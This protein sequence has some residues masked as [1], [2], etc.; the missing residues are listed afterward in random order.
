MELSSSTPEIRDICEKRSKARAKLGD[1]AALELGRI[2][3]DIEAFDSFPA[4][5]SMFGDRITDRGEAEKSFQME[6]G[7]LI[8]FRAGHPRN[9]GAGAIPTDWANTTRLLI[10]A[11]ETPDA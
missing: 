5:A 11:I 1:D 7:H 10:I 4:F 9:L 3:A 8:V 2:L 6:T